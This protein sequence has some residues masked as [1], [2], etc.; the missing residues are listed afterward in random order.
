MHYRILQAQ[1]D[2]LGWEVDYTP[3]HAKYAPYVEAT[4]L[5][6]RGY[7]LKTA[8]LMSTRDDFVPAEYLRW[9]KKTQGEV[10]TTLREGEWRHIF[11]TSTGRKMVDVFE[12]WDD[13][14]LGI[15][16]IGEVHRARLIG[17]KEVV[18]KVQAPGVEATFRNDMANVQRFCRLAMQHMVPALEEQERQF[19][20]EFDYVREAGNLELIYRDVMPIWGHKVAIPLPIMSLCTKEILV[21]DFLPGKKLVDGVLDQVRRLAPVMGLTEEELMEKVTKDVTSKSVTEAK[22]ESERVKKLLMLQDLVFTSN[23]PRFLYN[24]TPFRVITG[25]LPYHWT[26]APINLAEIL[27]L[28]IDVHAF[29]IFHSGAFNGDPH[30]GNILLLPDGRLGLIDYGQVKQMHIDD[31]IKYAKLII[32]LDNDDIEEVVRVQRDEF[33]ARSKYMDADVC[34]KLTAFWNDRDTED[35]MQG[36]NI[37]EFM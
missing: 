19:L 23:I 30:P 10:P 1:H 13:L 21:M 22:R 14:P 12:W 8:Q 5:E 6:M 27:E 18:I 15:A 36:M 26:E 20:T 32:A 4:T 7:Y 17:G 31:R 28:L 2:W 9:L 11:E 24:I 35:I 29:E 25:A 33:G 34:Y 3:L 37:Q 16:S